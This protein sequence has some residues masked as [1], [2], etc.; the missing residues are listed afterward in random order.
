MSLDH[1]LSLF[2]GFWSLPLLRL[3]GLL[4]HEFPI[5]WL[6]CKIAAIRSLGL[7]NFPSYILVC[8]LI[9]PFLRIGMRVG[10][11]GLPPPTYAWDD[12]Q[13]WVNSTDREGVFHCAYVHSGMCVWCDMKFSFFILNFWDIFSYSFYLDGWLGYG[14]FRRDQTRP[15]NHGFLEDFPSCFIPRLFCTEYKVSSN[16]TLYIHHTSHIT[17]HELGF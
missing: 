7:C 2:F 9:L 17:L 1:F 14:N 10:L 16:F 11:L 3:L 4:E 12:W 6:E 13:N 5:L 8:G 15:S